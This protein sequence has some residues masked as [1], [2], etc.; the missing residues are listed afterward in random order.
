M[1]RDELSEVADPVDRAV[2]ANE[3]IWGPHPDRTALRTMR[4]QAIRAA[5]DAGRTPDEVATRLQVTAA[6]LR[7]MAPVTAPK[8]TPT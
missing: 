2:L 7:W 8:P 1:S 4:A 3:L 5:L 6:D